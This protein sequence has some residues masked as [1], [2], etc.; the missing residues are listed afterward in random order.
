ML[1][2]KLSREFAYTIRLENIVIMLHY[3]FLNIGII[4]L[5]IPIYNKILFYCYCLIYYFNLFFLQ[6]TTTESNQSSCYLTLFLFSFLFRKERHLLSHFSWNYFFLNSPEEKLHW[7]QIEQQDSVARL[8]VF[9]EIFLL[10]TG[11]PES[12]YF[13]RLDF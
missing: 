4:F 7:R 13:S 5:N 11:G 6:R 10:K 9:F 3:C 8:H 2:Q 12:R 1:I